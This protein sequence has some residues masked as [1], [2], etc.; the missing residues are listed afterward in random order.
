MSLNLL[1]KN[2]LIYIYLH[3]INEQI[4]SSNPHFKSFP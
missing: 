2:I 3:I 1:L 4:V